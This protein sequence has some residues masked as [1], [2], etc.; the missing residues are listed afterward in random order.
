MADTLP[1]SRKGKNRGSLHSFYDPK[2]QESLYGKRDDKSKKV[3]PKVSTD[4]K[5]SAL[6][7]IAGGRFEIDRKVLL[8]EC[9]ADFNKAWFFESATRAITHRLDK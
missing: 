6:V 3:A 1:T 2:L 9:A 5:R 7:P 8:E 4:N